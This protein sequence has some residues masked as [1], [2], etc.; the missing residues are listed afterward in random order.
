MRIKQVEN[1][2]ELQQILE[3]QKKN[4][5]TALSES[6]AGAAGFVT[7]SHELE[8]LKEMNDHLPSIIAVENGNLAGYTLSMCKSFRNKIP[9]LIPMF[10]EIDKLNF[11]NKKL[12]ETE[13]LVGGQICV[14]KAYRGRGLFYKLY[15]GTRDFYKD[16]Y[17]FLITE[18]TSK[19]P[20]SMTAHLKCGFEA[21]HDYSMGGPDTWTILAWDWT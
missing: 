6:E 4:L 10:D 9:I 11:R 2:I 14:A 5:P 15:N 12:S 17:A 13:Y 16:D 3:L 8:L 18:V 21:I 20:G 19:N 7:V 1:T